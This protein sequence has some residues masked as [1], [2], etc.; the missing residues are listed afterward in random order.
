MVFQFQRDKHLQR[1][2]SNLKFNFSHDLSKGGLKQSRGVFRDR[3]DFQR[4]I[5]KWAKYPLHFF[6]LF[7]PGTSQICLNPVR[8]LLGH[9]SHRGLVSTKS[10]EFLIFE[11]VGR[12]LCNPVGRGE[13]IGSLPC[14]S[15]IRF[16][17][18]VLSARWKPCCSDG[19]GKMLKS[20]VL[21]HPISLYYRVLT[22]VYSAI[23]T[24]CREVFIGL[25]SIVWLTF[26]LPW[27]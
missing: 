22:I 7:W 23:G 10:I 17:L 14:L 3:D 9:K 12:C 15:W 6:I 5:C 20:S 8:H 25:H 2:W 18:R 27:E 21:G 19:T 13:A 24:N 4:L 26:P 16:T 1:K 11:K